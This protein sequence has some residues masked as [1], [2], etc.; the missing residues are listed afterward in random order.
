MWAKKIIKIGQAK[1]LLNFPTCE[2]ARIL[3]KLV[4]VGIRRL[5]II[6]VLIS[7]RGGMV[8]M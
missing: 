4:L 6:M 7:S 5:I 3:F 8:N 2:K 1:V